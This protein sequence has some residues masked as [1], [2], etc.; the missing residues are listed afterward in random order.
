MCIAAI[1]ASLSA[2][3]TMDTPK[4]AVPV[5]PKLED[6]L[7]RATEAKVAGKQEQAIT[8]W[9]ETATAY[10]QK[11]AQ[12]RSCRGNDL[13]PNASYTLPASYLW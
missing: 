10:Q 6:M 12:G 5:K 9:K 13:G 3:Q 4:V 7:A 8:L 2:C 11:I 1:A